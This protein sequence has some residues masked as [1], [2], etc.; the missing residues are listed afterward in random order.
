MQTFDVANHLVLTICVSLLF[1]KDKVTTCYAAT[2][3][4]NT[5]L[6]KVA[7]CCWK[8]NIGI[9]SFDFPVCPKLYQSTYDICC[10]SALLK[11]ALFAHLKCMSAH[12]LKN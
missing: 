9:K 12:L 5:S 2:A 3:M 4:R 11:H 6:T 7:I 8:I 1:L 10:E